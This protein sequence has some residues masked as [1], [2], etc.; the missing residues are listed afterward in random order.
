MDKTKI[1]N[2]AVNARKELIDS[3]RQRLANFGI[4]KTGIADE[5]PI[6]TAAVKYYTNEHF[7]LKGKAIDWR[8]Q[9]VSRIKQDANQE[10]DEKLNQFIDEVAYTWFNR[11]IAIRFMEVNDYLPSRTR[12]LSSEEGRIE[13]DMITHALEIEDDLGGYS[14]KERTQI[15]DALMSHNPTQLDKV[16]GMLFI[17]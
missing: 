16:F 14:D 5:L 13:P 12:V 6:S 11:I 17:K 4:D 10:W 9:I 3:V 8:K 15:T 2:F 7:P 1:K